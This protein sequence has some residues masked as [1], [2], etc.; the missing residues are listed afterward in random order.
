MYSTKTEVK[1]DSS[2]LFSVSVQSRVAAAFNLVD[3]FSALSNYFF[4]K[5]TKFAVW[6]SV[7]SK[8]NITE[9]SE[10]TQSYL[11]RQLQHLRHG[12][13]YFAQMVC[14]GTWGWKTHD[15][16]T[17]HHPA[18][19]LPFPAQRRHLFWP[20]ELSHSLILYTPRQRWQ[21]SIDHHTRFP[22][23]L[24]SW[25]PLYQRNAKAQPAWFYHILEIKNGSSIAVDC[26]TMK[27]STKQ[28]LVEH[29][30]ELTDL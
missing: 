15:H 2:P 7:S 22:S 29:I 6:L 25:P 26:V 5:G 10:W 11:N 18:R 1:N 12:H 9:I 3:T 14:A 28:F 27:L 19:S 13:S 17:A 24:Y 16:Y 30:V 4:K 20:Q 23:C 21:G 8:A